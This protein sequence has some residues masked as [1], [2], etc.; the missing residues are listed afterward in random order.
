M[1]PPTGVPLGMMTR[2]LSPRTGST[3]SPSKRS[4]GRLVLTLMCWFT[5]MARVVPAGTLTSAGRTTGLPPGGDCA[6]G[7]P[8]DGYCPGYWLGAGATPPAVAGVL[9]GTGPAALPAALGF[10][11]GGTVVVIVGVAWPGAG[12]CTVVVVVVPFLSV[13][14]TC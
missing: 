12:G 6:C 5:R 7:C 11:D 13:E 14:T 1:M 3:N 4:P 8:C 2:S 9:A 10:D